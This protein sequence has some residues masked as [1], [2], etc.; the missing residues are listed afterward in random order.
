MHA[1]CRS[2]PTKASSS[3]TPRF[4]RHRLCD[5]PMAASAERHHA[6]PHGRL[7]SSTVTF[8]CTSEQGRRGQPGCSERFPSGAARSNSTLRSC[9]SA[10]HPYGEAS[11]GDGAGLRSWIWTVTASACSST[12][13]VYSVEHKSCGL[14]GREPGNRIVTRVPSMLAFSRLQVTN[15]RSTESDGGSATVGMTIA[16]CDVVG[17]DVLAGSDPHDATAGRRMLITAARLRDVN[18]TGLWRLLLDM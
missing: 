15:P 1:Q 8:E 3:A 11:P 5:H 7:Y 16:S 12:T 13:A 17:A 2:A 14:N 4:L 6:S 18:P 10:V 9:P